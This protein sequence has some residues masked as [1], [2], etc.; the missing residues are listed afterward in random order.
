[1][2]S[3]PSTPRRNRKGIALAVMLVLAGALAALIEG[4]GSSQLAAQAPASL[5][6]TIFSY[7]GHDFVRTHTTLLT[8]TGKSALNT[9]LDRETAAFKA[10]VQKHS[11]VGDVTVF[12]KRYDA[13]YA[14]LTDD[15]GNLTGALFVAIPK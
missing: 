11:F 2:A 5:A 13:R 10:L 1:M 4:P 8:E 3:N 7:D 14:P 15:K 12:G 9:K 6:A